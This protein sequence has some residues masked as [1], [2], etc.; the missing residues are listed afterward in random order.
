[1]PCSVFIAT[2]LDGFI[3][4]PDGGID[5]LHPE[6]GMENQDYGYNGFI[7]DIDA[8]V[9]GR[10]SFEKVL[11]FDSG[12]YGSTRVVVLSTRPLTIPDRVSQTVEHMSGPPE[13]IVARLGGRGFTRLYVDGGKTV[14]SFLR[15]GLIDRMTITRIPVILGEGIPLFGATGRDVRLEHVRTHAYP[16]G[17]VQ[18]EYQVRR[19]ESA[20]S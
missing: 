1:V 15:A 4:R 20:K 16:D 10:G 5:W 9:M 14:Q 19:E 6:G 12:P 2:S 7:R 13:E 18:T 3:A 8:I 11:T 17:L